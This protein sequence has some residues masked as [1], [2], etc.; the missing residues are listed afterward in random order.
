MHHPPHPEPTWKATLHYP[1]FVA[2]TRKAFISFRTELNREYRTLQKSHSGACAKLFAGC[3]R[4]GSRC[5]GRAVSRGTRHA[6]RN[7]TSVQIDRGQGKR[8]F[9]SVLRKDVGR[10]VAD[11]PN[12]RRRSLSNGPCCAR[13]GFMQERGTTRGNCQFRGKL[14]APQ[15]R[16]TCRFRGKRHFRRPLLRKCTNLALFYSGPAGINTRGNCHFHASHMR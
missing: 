11:F 6:G 5:E 10:R 3:V 16:G 14:A 12:V 8:R 2:H 13:D 1:G 15:L 9:R 4:F 7:V